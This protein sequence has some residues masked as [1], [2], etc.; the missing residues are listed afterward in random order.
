M[1]TETNRFIDE[2]VQRR[3]APSASS[4]ART[5]RISRSTVTASAIS[6]YYS[7]FYGVT[8]GSG[9]TVADR[10]K[11]GARVGILNQGAFLSV[12]AHASESAPVLRGVAMMRRV[13]CITVPDPVDAEHHRSA[14]AAARPEQ[15]D[16]DAGAFDDP[17]DDP[18]CASCHDSIDAFGF[19]FESFDGM[20]KYRDDRRRLQ[21]RRAPGR[22][23]GGVHPLASDGGYE[24][25][26][27][28]TTTTVAGTDFDGQAY[29]D[30]NALATALRQQR[31]GARAACARQLFRC[32]DGP[33][34]R[35]AARDAEQS[36]VEHLEAAARRPAGQVI[37]M[38]IAYVRSPLFAQRR[39]P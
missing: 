2:V 1:D 31:P 3:R 23:K 22:R 13:A 24:Y 5:G 15:S 35:I 12:F 16:H 18:G 36:F 33:Q 28:D 38:L 10:P 20:G 4:W 30:S 37:E 17:R 32:V 34:R 19:A 8:G 21:G 14:A 29:A 39:T 7:K 6:S 26:S 11:G 25:L 9:A 27:I